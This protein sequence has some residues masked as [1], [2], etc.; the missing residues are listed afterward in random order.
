MWTDYKIN[1][2]CV[3]RIE[4]ND[5]ESLLFRLLQPSR[6]KKGRLDNGI[7]IMIGWVLQD[8]VLSY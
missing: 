5:I 4:I 8:T 6:G 1:F 7:H 3:S 2:L